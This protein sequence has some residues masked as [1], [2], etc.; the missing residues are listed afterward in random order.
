MTRLSEEETTV[1]VSLLRLSIALMFVLTYIGIRPVSVR[2]EEATI[3]EMGTPE[4]PSQIKRKLPKPKEEIGLKLGPFRLHPSFQSSVE[5]DDNILLSSN[6]EKDDVLFT[7]FPG[8][9]AQVKMGDHRA[10]FGYGAEFINFVDQAEENSVNHFAHGLM[11]LVF[12]NLSLELSH[13]FEDATGRLFSETSIRDEVMVNSSQALLRYDR[14]RWAAELGWRHNDI[15]HRVAALDASDYEEDVLAL[16]GG[17]KVL[18]KILVLVEVD[19]GDVHYDQNTANADQQYYQVWTGLKGDFSRKLSTALKVGYQNRQMGDLPGGRKDYGSSVAE[20]DLLWKPRDSSAI[21][22]AYT[23][24]VRPSTFSANNWYQQDKVSLSLRQRFL[25]KW[26]ITPLVS[27]QRNRYP[28]VSLLN[29]EAKER[30]DDFW[31]GELELRYQIKDWLSTG[32][33]YRYRERGSNYDSLEFTN[34]RVSFD[35]KFVY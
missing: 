13:G 15:D 28:E 31:V 12:D 4:F 16:L 27:W 21:R 1:R 17:Y 9:G 29:G 3:D 6:G 19:V 34:N 30:R 26:Y 24:T 5:Y 23:R 33:A 10:E 18:H 8:I 25:R 7:Q 14:P 35:V 11:E 20:I 22:S 2:A 32:L